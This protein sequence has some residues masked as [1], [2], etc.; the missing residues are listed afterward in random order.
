MSTEK[1]ILLPGISS[2]HAAD[3]RSFYVLA[4]SVFILSSHS[5]FSQSQFLRVFLITPVCMTTMSAMITRR[6]HGSREAE[7]WFA[8]SPNNGGIKQLPT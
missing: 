7:I 4:F 2:Y 8:R 6:Y 5:F 1:R 3:I